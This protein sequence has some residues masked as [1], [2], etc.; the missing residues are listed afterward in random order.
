MMNEHMPVRKINAVVVADEARRALMA[1]DDPVEI[2]KI[3]ATLDAAETLM[4]ATGLYPIDEMRPVNEERMRAR[5]RLGQTLASF[6]RGTGPGRGKKML[7]EPTS[8]RAFL[9]RLTLDP[10]TALEAQRI[11]ALPD[12]VL[13]KAFQD[14]RDRPDLLHYTDL[15][16]IARP[17]WIRE[18]RRETHKRIAEQASATKVAAPEKFGP[19]AL[20]YADPPWRFETYSE[21]AT[22]LPDEHYPTLTDQEIIDFRIH[23]RCIPDISGPKCALFLWCTSSNLV[24][25]LDVMRGW[26]FTYKTQA[27]WDKERV[28]VGLIFRNQHE[29]LLYGSRGNPPKPLHLPPSVFR[30]PRGAHSAKPPEIRKEIERMYPAFGK[31]NR[32]EMFC[33]GQFEGWTCVGNEAGAS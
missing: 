1:T 23:D 8:F 17:Y 7:I 31:D 2:R 18:A 9:K 28:G 19:F 11:A 15:I 5:W 22:R 12:D 14:W 21:I 13:A 20:I 16:Q 25:A 24:R 6:V 3:E 33:R 10:R 27:V 32:I 26:G 4:R 29:V 30:Y